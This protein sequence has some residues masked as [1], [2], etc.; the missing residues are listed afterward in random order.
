MDSTVIV[1]LF[2]LILMEVV[3]GIDN[4]VFISIISGKLPLAQQGRARMV[5]LGLALLMRI[6][7]L[8]ALTHIIGLSAPLFTILGVTLSWK[9]LILLIGGLFLVG[10]ATTEI[11][12]KLEGADDSHSTSKTVRGFGAAIAQIVLIDMVFSIDSILTA[13]GLTTVLW[14]MIV[15]VLVSVGIMLAFAKSVSGF[16]NRHPTVKMLALSF[17]LM[18]GLLLMT[19]AFHVE[20]PKGYV[21]FA[22]AFSIVVE[23]LNL[24][25][26]K[27]SEPVKLRETER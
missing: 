4:I 16:V 5:G 18:I 12:G 13:V 24:K 3:L 9:D 15:A 17:L 10:K 27:K 1:S 20:V 26:R 6:L 8:F 19:E 22:M 7:L 11:H 2:T 14:V 21:Y 25:L 23:L